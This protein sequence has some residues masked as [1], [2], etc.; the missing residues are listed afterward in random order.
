MDRLAGKVAIVT[1]AGTGIGRAIA[2]AFAA[3][4]AALLI[5]ELNLDTGGQVEAEIAQAGGQAY[6]CSTDVGKMEDAQRMVAAA[7]DRWG[8]VDILVNNAGIAVPGT[9]VDIS[10]EDWN[11]VL[12]IN[13]T[14]VW[15]GMKHAI[16]AM[17]QV[18]GGSIVNISSIQSLVGFHNWS[19]YAAS[20]GGINALTRQAANE[21]AGQGIRVNAIAPTTIMTPMNEAILKN[22]KDRESVLRSLES[23]HPL[24]R[25]GRPEEVAMLAVF[26][27]SDEAGLIT[28]QVFVIDGGRIVRGD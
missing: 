26:L 3:E 23:A 14:G 16:P 20:K 13:L 19:G 2:L 1:G 8:R 18:G 17:V 15:R 27:A 5:A 21:Y 28:G 25:V 9:V 7:L 11:R 24:G 12:D 10:E 22:S 6:F 4:G